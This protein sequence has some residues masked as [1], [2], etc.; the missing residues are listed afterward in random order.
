MGPGAQVPAQRVS[1]DLRNDSI[2]SLFCLIEGDNVPFRVDVE[3]DC[4]INQLKKDIHKEREKGAFR[5]VDA[6][7]LRL[8]KV[9]LIES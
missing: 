1:N 8:Y 3:V 5:D 6:A 7:D 9:S 2:R 4:E